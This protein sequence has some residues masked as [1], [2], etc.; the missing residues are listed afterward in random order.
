MK[1]VNA[2]LALENSNLHQIV[3]GVVETVVRNE[4]GTLGDTIKEM[5]DENQR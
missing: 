4:F 5:L 2:A 3:N 1:S